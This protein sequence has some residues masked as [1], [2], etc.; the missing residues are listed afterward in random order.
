MTRL[1]SLDDPDQFDHQELLPAED[2]QVM[3]PTLPAAQESTLI[4]EEEKA[5]LR[6]AI[7]I[8][9]PEYRDAILRCDIQQVS[10]QEVADSLN[11]TLATLRMRLSRGRKRLHKILSQPLAPQLSISKRS[12]SGAELAAR[13][14]RIRRQRDERD[15]ESSQMPPLAKP[16]RGGFLFSEVIELDQK[17][18][19]APSRY[20]VSKVVGRGR[21]R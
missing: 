3:G 4:Q 8:L 21:P 2:E 15:V 16:D 9:K 14:E 10:A 7:Q 6:A 1:G 17:R 20:C 13:L 19:V 18:Q 5:R 11:I 12:S